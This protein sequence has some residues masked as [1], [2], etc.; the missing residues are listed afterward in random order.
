MNRKTWYDILQHAAASWD[1]VVSSIEQT[2]AILSVS[3]AATSGRLVAFLVT[4]DLSPAF[5]KG[6][7]P[8]LS[9]FGTHLQRWKKSEKADEI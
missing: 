7:D 6:V 9:D 5:E 2:K 3:V 4:S 8:D 1:K